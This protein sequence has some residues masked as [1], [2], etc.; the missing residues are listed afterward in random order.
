MT[1]RDLS[2]TNYRYCNKFDH[3][4]NDCAD[5]KAVRQQNQLRRQRQCKQR[6][7]HQ[8]HPP[9]PGRQRSR[10]ER[11]KYGAHIARLPPTVTPIAA[12]GRQTGQTETSTSPKPVLR[13]SLGSISRGIFLC[14]TTPTRSPAYHYQRRGSCLQPSPPKSK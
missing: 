1:R 7:E 8:P 5:F 12:P 10:G 14:E 4:R 3:Y 2:N 11:G 6:G 13:A 9:N